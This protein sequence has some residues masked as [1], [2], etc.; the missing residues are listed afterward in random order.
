MDENN[1]NENNEVKVEE[2][3]DNNTN[4]PKKSCN[5]KL[6]IVIILGLVLIVLAVALYLKKS[7]VEPEQTE[8]VEEVVLDY[9]YEPEENFYKLQEAGKYKTDSVFGDES[10]QS[11]QNNGIADGIIINNMEEFELYATLCTESGYACG[12]GIPVSET[13]FETQSLI[14][15]MYYNDTSVAGM[16]ISEMNNSG[17]KLSLHLS[18]SEGDAEKVTDGKNA[19]ILYLF[20]DKVKSNAEMEFST[21][22]YGVELKSK[23]SEKIQ[24]EE[25]DWREEYTE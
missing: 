2:K 17:N 21:V 4:T 22:K 13:Y 3:K 5:K 10:I 19:E 14:V 23:E 18:I 12:V 16:K 20:A 15:Y 25:E 24:Y 6:K 11:L 7:N 9:Y 1:L 8:P